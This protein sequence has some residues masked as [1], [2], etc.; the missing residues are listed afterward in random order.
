MNEKSI[1][2]TLFFYSDKQNIRKI[3]E[4]ND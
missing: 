4:V 3:I 2:Q 1:H